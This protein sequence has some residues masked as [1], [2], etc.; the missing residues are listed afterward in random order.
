M[1]YNCNYTYLNKD[2]KVLIS[3]RKSACFSSLNYGENSHIKKGNYLIVHIPLQSATREDASVLLT[4]AMVDYWI[5]L[6]NDLGFPMEVIPKEEVPVKTFPFKDGFHIKIKD[7]DV[8]SRRFRL[9]CAT[10]ARYL[11]EE[12]QPLLVKWMYDYR[13]SMKNYSAYKKFQFGYTF[14]NI[15]LPKGVNRAGTGHS[16]SRTDL[17]PLFTEE[18]EFKRNIKYIKEKDGSVHSLFIYNQYGGGKEL[19]YPR[20]R[21]SAYNTT[22]RISEDEKASVLSILMEHKYN[23]FLIDIAELRRT[24]VKMRGT[25]DNLRNK[26]IKKG[27]K[28]AQAA[29]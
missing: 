17:G 11:W 9:A 1:G 8:K 2:N 10:Y 15:K 21:I 19:P 29:W 20:S 24:F 27:E 18:R 6:G 26:A 3:G 16:L 12:S 23:N 5:K 14:W 7:D 28:E 13:N 22:T 4:K 25:T